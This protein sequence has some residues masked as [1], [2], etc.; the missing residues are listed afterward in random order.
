MSAVRASAFSDEAMIPLAFCLL[1]LVSAAPLPAAQVEPRLERVVLS[2]SGVAVLDHAVEVEAEA[3]IELIV[4]AAQ[5]DDFLKSFAVYDS[6]GIVRALTL[7]G[8]AFARDLLR[9]LPLVEG[10]LAS[11]EALL[12]ALKGVSVAIGGPKALKGR[13]VAVAP[14]ERKEGK[15]R[16]I[17]HRLT[18]AT[19]EGLRSL[20]LDEADPIRIL[21]HDRAQ[22]LE[23]AL[24]RLAAARAPASRRVTLRLEGPGPRQV[25]L[26]W[27]VEA[28]VWKM[29]YRA[30]L[31]PDAV[32]L[33]GWA[34]VDNRSGHNWQEVELLLVA[35]APVTLR[36]PLAE[37]VWAERPEAPVQ[38]PQPIRPRRDEETLPPSS[39]AQ[40]APKALAP[41]REAPAA[42]ARAAVQEPAAVP[43]AG[44]AEAA[45]RTVFRV[46]GRI[47]LPDGA[48][49]LVPVLD[50]VVLAEPILLVRGDEAQP[51]PYAALRVVNGTD[52]TLPPGILTVFAAGEGA[53]SEFL[54]D[55]ELPQMPPGAVRL[56]PYAVDDAVALAVEAESEDRITKV[57]I[58]DGILALE[59]VSRRLTRYRLKAPLG[60]GRLLVLEHPK[61]PEFRLAEPAATAESAR[62][63]RFERRIAPQQTLDLTVVLERPELERVELLDL[64]PDRLA[65]LFAGRTLPEPLRAALAE[66]A[67]RRA[68]LADATRA[69]EQLEREREQ[70]LAEQ[71]RLR[72]NLAAVPAA[73][74]LARRLLAALAR[75]EDRLEELDKE[76]AHARA[77]V[78]AAEAK[79]R[80]FI[81]DLVL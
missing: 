40:P 30:L 55:A 43:A 58:A 53:R 24:A 47:S 69:R 81:R 68:A 48:S 67:A 14:E 50:R 13:I 79:L 3:R 21:D 16:L 27:L 75:S 46:P 19:N 34:V 15:T 11:L 17:R 61:A 70:L 10:D 8:E 76:L 54:G 9:D 59:R 2:S 66:I 71:E 26:A 62:F 72:A 49:G 38:L 44:A 18:L 41:P 60:E 77:A 56:V 6:Q 33:Q 25:R 45:R 7:E 12:R 37:L 51:Q 22:L 4:P 52:H 39:L 31:E 64:D 23:T 80:A 57:K 63:F 32:R 42:F 36:Q 65:A 20:F 5:L 74:D 35:G 29:T 1:F 73:S 28:P 78:A